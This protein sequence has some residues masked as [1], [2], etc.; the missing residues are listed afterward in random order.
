MKNTSYLSASPIILRVVNTLL[1]AFICI[2]LYGAINLSYITVTGGASCPTVFGLPACYIVA[3]AYGL[4]LLAF[5]RKIH[6]WSSYMFISG[7]GIAVSFALPASLIELFRA[8][9]CPSSSS[10]LPLCYLSLALCLLIMI[11]WFFTYPKK[12][13]TKN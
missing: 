6:S 3:L 9:T 10:G 7:L 1:F 11:T 13:K 4:M 5:F 8:G 12:L 2:G